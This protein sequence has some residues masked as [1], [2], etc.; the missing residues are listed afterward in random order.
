MDITITFPDKSKKKHKKGI[1]GRE[2]ADSISEG[3]GRAAVAIK[4][5]GTTT[6]LNGSINKDAKVQI[7]TFKDEEGRSI[8][9][10]SS[11]HL[12]AHAVKRLFPKT[13][14]ILSKDIV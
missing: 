13:K 12:L 6:D 1:T 11:A 4:I 8:Y 9:W 3:L 5:D 14:P 7:L 10:H 2:I